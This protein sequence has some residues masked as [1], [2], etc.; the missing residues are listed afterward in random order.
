MI[1]ML[2]TGIPGSRI[3]TSKSYR[4]LKIIVYTL[5]YQPLFTKTLFHIIL[6]VFLLAK[7]KL[8]TMLSFF[9][10]LNSSWT[11]INPKDIFKTIGSISLSQKSTKWHSG[12]HDS[13]LS[14]WNSWLIYKKLAWTC[15]HGYW[16]MHDRNTQKIS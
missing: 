16:T 10:K 12:L 5:T 8:K 13:A 15:F 6:I 14:W 7:N 9:L 2:Y 4:W 1:L 11:L 3:W